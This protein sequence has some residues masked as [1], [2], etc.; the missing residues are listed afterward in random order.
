MPAL[1]NKKTVA[2]PRSAV[3]EYRGKQTRTGNS[4][5][6]RF[7]GALFK[8]HP[9][10][11][12]AVKAHIIA[13]GRMLVTAE[14]EDRQKTDPVLASFLAFLGQDIADNPEKVRPLNAARAR[15]IGRLTKGI[16][17]NPDEDLGS[18]SLI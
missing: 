12:G 15:R 13:P 10:F 16:A 17:V 3:V 6:F 14:N 2:A 1:K 18:E 9:E 5:G 7:E 11:N 8:S 4:S